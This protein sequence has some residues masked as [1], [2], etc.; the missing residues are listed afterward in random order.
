[1]SSPVEVG[2]DEETGGGERVLFQMIQRFGGGSD[3]DDVGSAF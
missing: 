1:M 2:E 3:R